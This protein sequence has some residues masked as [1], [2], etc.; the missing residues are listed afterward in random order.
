MERQ[1]ADNETGKKNKQKFKKKICGTKKNFA[2]FQRFLWKKQLKKALFFEVF[3]RNFNG[4]KSS[5]QA[6]FFFH[7][8]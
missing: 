1:A 3:S 4:D 2:D 7:E 5:N 6:H 8:S